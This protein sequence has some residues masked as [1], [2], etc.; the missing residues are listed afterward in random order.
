MSKRDFEKSL[1][2]AV[3]EALSSLGEFLKQ[4]TY[5]HL[6]ESFNIPKREIPYKI[7]AFTSGIEEILGSEAEY[8][9]VMVLQ[10]LYEKVGGFFER[11]ESKES[12]FTEDVKRARGLLYRGLV[13]SVQGGLAVF[14]LENMAD[15]SSFRLIAANSAAAK[16]AG[17]AAEIILG[18]TMGE[19]YPQISKVETPRILEVIRSGKAK[20]LTEFRVGSEGVAERY[21]VAAFPL[22]NDCIG[23]VF[24]NLIEGKRSEREAQGSQAQLEDVAASMGEWRWEP[25][26]QWRQFYSGRSRARERWVQRQITH[27]PRHAEY[28][29][30]RGR[31]CLE[32]GDLPRAREFLHQAEEQ[33]REYNMSEEAFENASLRIKAYSLGEKPSLQEYF[34]V[35]EEYFQRYTDFS[36]HEYFVENLATYCQW[37]GYKYGEEGKFDDARA[38]YA[39]AEEIFLM[40]NRWENALFNSSRRAFTHKSENHMDQYARTAEAFFEKYKR[41]SE[42]RYYKEIRAHY[43]S[44][45]ASES[46]DS[47][48]SVELL[49]AAEK[50]FLE[51][52]QRQM[53]FENAC[54]RI[55][56]CWIGLS[57]D[58][59]QS[60]KRCFE[61]TERFFEVYQDFSEHE[62]FRRRLAKYYLS[63]ARVL[64]TQL[65]KFLH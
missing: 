25:D 17:D 46:S 33:Y 7:E 22:S 10:K 65:K 36:M 23:L 44:Q 28:L 32:S 52:N 51:I 43:Y 40:L 6:E 1:L 15:P 35:A 34:R 3:D 45:K 4:E 16:M 13:N 41:L 26:T 63:Q 54:R 62:G 30:L 57:S 20:N 8:L 49:I 60:T 12:S 9:E 59:E 14:H 2:E 37:K 53:A 47:S 24:K 56:L 29:S 58:D 61:A 48:R 38:S 31:E 64:A 19:V 50:L 21:S 5:R 39:Q 42:N 27:E 11:N 55:D 18:K